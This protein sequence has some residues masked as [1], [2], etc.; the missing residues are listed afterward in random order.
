[1]TWCISRSRMDSPVT[2]ASPLTAMGPSTPRQW[3]GSGA[4][5]PPLTA[6]MHIGYTLTRGYNGT[7]SVS[8]TLAYPVLGSLSLGL[9]YQPELR[10]SPGR[11]EESPGQVVDQRWFRCGLICHQARLAFGSTVQRTCACATAVPA[12]I[13]DIS[14][15][16]K[17]FMST[18]LSPA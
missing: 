13:R 7:C 1:M 6:S 5:T 10:P 4:T 9:M 16:V 8:S 15:A 2:R 3:T 18:V 17:R 14:S 11:Q 12:K